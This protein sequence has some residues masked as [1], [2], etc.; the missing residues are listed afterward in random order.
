MIQNSIFKKIIFVT[1]NLLSILTLFIF[2]M[3]YTS[4]N[5]NMPWYDSCG[6][7]FLVIIILS[8]LLAIIGASLLALNKKLHFNK[9]NARFHF[10]AMFCTVVPLIVDGSLSTPTLI[11][12]GSFCVISIILIIYSVITNLKN[13]TNLR[14]S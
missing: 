5:K 2:L 3:I 14:L 8:P 12:G 13:K 10:I 6:M 4:L 1:I 7:Q 9:P 11:I